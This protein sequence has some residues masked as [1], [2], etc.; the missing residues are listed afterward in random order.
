MISICL[1]AL[2]ACALV[3]LMFIVQVTW[4]NDLVTVD[5]VCLFFLPAMVVVLAALV[6]S[7]HALGGVFVGMCIGN[8]YTLESVQWYRLL[9]M[10]AVPA[11]SG[12]ISIYVSSGTNKNIRDFLDVVPSI[13]EIDALDILYFC[14]I[15]SI[16]NSVLYG[17]N[18]LTDYVQ[19]NHFT[20]TYFLGTLFGELSGSFIGFVMLNLGYSLISRLVTWRR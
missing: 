2:S 13:S 17:L 5:H 3:L 12:M 7:Y 18:S 1:N 14:V 8:Y 6:L 15:Y 9:G 4:L 19:G 20:L 10:S 16:S 11:I